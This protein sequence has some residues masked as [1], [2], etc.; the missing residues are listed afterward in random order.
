[1]DMGVPVISYVQARVGARGV[2]LFAP[3]QSGWHGAL[4]GR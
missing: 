1:M 3:L 2:G 4:H